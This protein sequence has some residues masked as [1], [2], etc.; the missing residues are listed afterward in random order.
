MI[1]HLEANK[2][3]ART[4]SISRRNIDSVVLEHLIASVLISMTIAIVELE[5]YLVLARTS[6]TEEILFRALASRACSQ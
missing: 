2:Y 3:I 6:S 1:L 4:A 5:L